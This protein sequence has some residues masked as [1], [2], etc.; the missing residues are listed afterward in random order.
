VSSFNCT[1]T[2]LTPHIAGIL[3]RTKYTWSFPGFI[4]FP[5]FLGSFHSRIIGKLDK[6]IRSSSNSPQKLFHFYLASGKTEAERSTN[7]QPVLCQKGAGSQERPVNDKCLNA[8]LF[9]FAITF[10]SVVLLLHG[11]G[12]QLPSPLS[13]ECQIG[14]CIAAMGHSEFAPYINTMQHM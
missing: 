7:R 4:L 8:K 5:A 2:D 12:L 6:D 1:T 10:S 13:A 3:T 9:W 11:S 14:L